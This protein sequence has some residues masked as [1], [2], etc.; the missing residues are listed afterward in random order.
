MEGARRAE[1][2]VEP[3]WRLP[4]DRLLGAGGWETTWWGI[5]VGAEEKGPPFRTGQSGETTDISEE[6]L[7]R[8]MRERCPATRQ[9]DFPQVVPGTHKRWPKVGAG[10]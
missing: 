1:P 10:C 7:S 6:D 5:V 2:A 4:F 9:S 8:R 3:W